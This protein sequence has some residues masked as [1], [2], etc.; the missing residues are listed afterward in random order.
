MRLEPDREGFGYHAEDLGRS[1]ETKE[2][3]GCE[4]AAV[5]FA[6]QAGPSGTHIEG[7]LARDGC[8]VAH[9][10]SVTTKL[11]LCSEKAIRL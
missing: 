1:Q 9:T 4:V 7:G 8:F 3:H 10:V 11:Y 2:N 5:R 6:L